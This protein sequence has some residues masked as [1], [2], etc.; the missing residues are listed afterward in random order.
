M[1]Q[2]GW[3]EEAENSKARNFENLLTTEFTAKFPL[4]PKVTG[5]CMDKKN[6]H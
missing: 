2:P 6:K 5:V 1:N 3:K 4:Y